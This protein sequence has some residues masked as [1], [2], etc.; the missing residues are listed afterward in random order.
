MGN[1]EL[2]IYR[3]KRSVFIS[4]TFR[5]SH[6]QLTDPHWE[7]RT[8]QR[9][10]R[11]SKTQFL[12]GTNSSLISTQNTAEVPLVGPSKYSFHFPWKVINR[13]EVLHSFPHDAL[14]P[15][16]TTINR[17]GLQTQLQK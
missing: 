13:I 12:I 16:E 11:T 14:A 7:T 4:P 15:H 9:N 17:L 3:A 5:D 10:Y 8:S 2:P 1:E 6:R